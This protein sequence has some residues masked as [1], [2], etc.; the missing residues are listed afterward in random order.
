MYDNDNVTYR[1]GLNWKDII[2]KI[3]MFTL[4]VL[5]LLWL[6]PKANLD[7]FYDKVYT[8][9]IKTMKEAARNYY[10]VDR[11][12]V[13]VGDKTS[14]T[15]KEMIDNK[16]VIRFN[17][18]D[19]K[20]CDESN[21]KV[22]VTKLSDSEYSLKVQLNCG[23]QNDYILETIGCTTVCSNGTCKTVLTNDDKTVASKTLENEDGAEGEDSAVERDYSDRVGNAK[24]VDNTIDGSTIKV[25]LYQHKKAIVTTKTV[26]T[27]PEGY[28]KNGTKCLKNTTGAAI[29]AT[30]VYGP[31]QVV[32]T[33]AKYNYSGD[34]K[35][36]AD[37]IKTEIGTDYTCPEGYT[38]N[39]SYCIKYTDAI[40]NPINTTITCPSGF[41]QNGNQCI[42]SY[43]ATATT[44]VG[45][46]NCPSGGTLNGTTCTLSIAATINSS[47]SY[48]CPT[49]YTLSG[50]SCIKSYGATYKAGATSYSCPNGGT[51][52]GTKCTITNTA[53]SKTTYTCPSGYTKNGSSCYKVYTATSKTSYNCPT[54]YKP[55]SNGKK[56]TKT[57][58]STIN[59]T[60]K[61]TYSCP[62]G[63][64][65]G[66]KCI[67]TS[68]STINATP[69]TTY[70]GWVSKGTKYF[71]S[72]N[73][74]KTSNDGTYKY[75]YAGA[76]SG[77]VCGSPCG[78][79][80]IWYKY[81]Y[82]T[83]ST[84]TSYSCP[85][86]TPSGSKCIITSTS[87]INATPKTTY[88]CS[89]G[90]PSGN[91]CIITSTSTINATSNKSYSCPNGGKREGNKCTITKAATSNKTYSCP[92]GY[93]KNGSRCTKSY[94]A[95]PKTGTGA[96]SC[97]NGGSLNGSTCTLYTT[98][99]S[100]S[101]INYTCPSGYTKNGNTCIKQYTATYTPG[102]T[103]YTCPNGGQLNG[104]S[105]V[106]TIDVTIDVGTPSYT[107]PTG[108]S[109]NEATKKCEYKISA[110]PNKQYSYTC[111]DGFT[112]EGEGETMKCFKTMNGTE[113]Y[114]CEDADAKLEGK[115]CIKTVKGEITNYTCPTDY[116]LND[117]KCTKQTTVIIDAT[118]STTTSTSY[119]YIWS[120]SSSLEGWE[121]TGKTKTQIKSYTAGQK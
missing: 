66:S 118:V 33:E 103:S 21:S 12:P 24:D 101:Y 28:T 82:Y 4:F 39:G 69:K 76:V 35:V 10:T 81:T 31:D 53:T 98:P 16:M 63:K 44:G 108:Y 48:T 37:V 13:S 34:Y 88:S 80:G 99:N 74:V 38:L 84:K 96:Y 26:Y 19:G 94:N 9:N 58:T 43:T 30:P 114:Y 120:E 1:V 97:P 42:K 121:F 75:V 15:L 110:T 105:C 8:D 61:T 109:Y 91:K 119:K 83:R 29:D 36:Y 102:A 117:K 32:T 54:G 17:D 49:G 79:K 93:T 67:V 51:L 107:C 65:S 59:A 5:L 73:G 78:N 92:S 72:A 115:Q 68:T 55:S 116:I 6:F 100:S 11:L 62:K 112:S 85:K 41:T 71:K 106:T 111:P 87:T 90:T 104:T 23:E 50:S 95:T 46:Y 3:I 47:S 40:E 14:M 86:G 2:I 52:N 18:K 77:A 45:A 25:T 64:P 27:C 113:T 56:C 7:V 89:K 22:E 60:P 20:T 70:T 57:S